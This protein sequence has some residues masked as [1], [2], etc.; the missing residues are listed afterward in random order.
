MKK[1][2]AHKCKLSDLPLLLRYKQG[3]YSLRDTAK[4]IGISPTTLTRMHD[5]D[6]PDTATLV[7]VAEY[8]DLE[9]VLLAESKKQGGRG[10]TPPPEAT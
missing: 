2:Y 8:L 5:G 9:L 4:K 3:S 6:I 10:T 1:L 7:K